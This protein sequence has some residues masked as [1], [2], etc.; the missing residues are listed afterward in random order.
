[1]L[2][3]NRFGCSLCSSEKSPQPTE[4]F[5]KF[6]TFVSDGPTTTIFFYLK[7][8]RG[9]YCG[10]T[11]FKRNFYSLDEKISTIIVK[12][13]AFQNRRNVGFSAEKTTFGRFLNVVFLTIFVDVLSNRFLKI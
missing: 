10:R 2:A 11:F 8:P 1:M 3:Y 12:N 4:Y 5:H 7:H 6:L 9:R 13:T